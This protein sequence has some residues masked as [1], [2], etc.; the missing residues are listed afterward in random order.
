MFSSKGEP[1]ASKNS[2][3]YRIAKWCVQAGLSKQ[4]EVVS[5]KTGTTTKKRRFT[6]SQGGVR[7]A[8]AHERAEAG[9]NVYG[10]AAR[11]SHSD[12]KSSAPYV[13]YIDRKCLAKVSLDR[14]EEAKLVQAVPKNPESRAPVV[15]KQG[16]S[17]KSGSP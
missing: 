3:G 2:L 16:Y 8:T 11:L 10:I 14:V 9:A 6:R 5:K 1:F 17:G 15:R 7:K 13:R 4:V 12:F